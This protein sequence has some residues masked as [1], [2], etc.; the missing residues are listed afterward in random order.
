MSNCNKIS[1][2]LSAYMDGELTTTEKELVE[3][4][5]DGFF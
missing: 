3:K 4:H 5:L 1:E 2:L